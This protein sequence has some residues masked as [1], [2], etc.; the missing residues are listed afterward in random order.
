[1]FMH[2]LPL[3]VIFGMRLAIRA[4]DR[5][6]RLVCFEAQVARFVLLSQ[7]FISQSVVAEHQIVMRLQVFR[8]D[9]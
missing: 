4:G 3:I 5:L 8:I 6:R 9:R 7:L 1:M 2:S